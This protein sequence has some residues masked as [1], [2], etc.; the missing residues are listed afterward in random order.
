MAVFERHWTVQSGLSSTPVPGEVRAIECGH[1]SRDLRRDKKRGYSV[2][3]LG[4]Q[5]YFCCN[6]INS[7]KQCKIKKLTGDLFFPWLHFY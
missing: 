7:S 6:V 2:E 5:F 3:L 1:C 4:Q